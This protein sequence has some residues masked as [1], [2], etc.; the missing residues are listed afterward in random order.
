MFL[1][2]CN[3]AIFAVSRVSTV[4]YTLSVTVGYA[5]RYCRT[6]LLKRLFVFLV[7]VDSYEDGDGQALR[8]TLNRCALEIPRPKMET[9]Q[10]VSAPFTRKI[11][12]ERERERQCEIRAER[13]LAQPEFLLHVSREQY[14]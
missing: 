1:I 10:F 11:N 5:L 6:Q 13:A 2:M 14:E 4:P 8:D 7:D 3:T 9:K 12:R